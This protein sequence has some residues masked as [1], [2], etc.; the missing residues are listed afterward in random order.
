MHDGKD[1][2]DAISLI[3]KLSKQKYINENNIT[4]KQIQGSDASCSIY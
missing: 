2:A 1:Y 3:V 4:I